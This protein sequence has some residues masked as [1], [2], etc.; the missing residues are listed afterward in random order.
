MTKVLDGSYARYLRALQTVTS[1][2]SRC[3]GCRTGQRCVTGAQ[4][5]AQA[6][7]NHGIYHR[8]L[9]RLKCCH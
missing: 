4:L 5:E 7:R 3:S 8:E 1:H 9:Q 6:I 2:K